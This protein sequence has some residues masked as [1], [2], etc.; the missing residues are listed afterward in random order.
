M[1][2]ISVVVAVACTSLSLAACAEAKPPATATTA[3]GPGPSPSATARAAAPATRRTDAATNVNISDEI[4]AKCGITDADAYFDFNSANVTS[5]DVRPLDQVAVCFTSGPL[6]GH[7]LRLVGHADPRGSVE[8]NLQLGHYR[9]DAVQAYLSRK[10]LDK[11][12]A[13]STSR[14]ALDATGQDETGWAK[15]RRVDVMLAP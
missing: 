8:Y 13:E 11:S 14:G 2:R 12:K 6:A 15:D 7:S 1:S 9:A 5:Y 3:T 10:G 4:R